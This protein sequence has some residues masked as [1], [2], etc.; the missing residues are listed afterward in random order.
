MVLEDKSKELVMKKLI[1]IIKSLKLKQ[2]LTVFLAGSL[3]AISTACSNDGNVAQ[4]GGKTYTDNAKRAMSD[5]YDD[6]DANQNFKGGINGYDDD[7][8]YDSETAGK[9]QTLIDTAKRRKADDLGEYTDNVLERSVL[10]GDVDEK[11]TESFSDKLERNK[12]KASNYIDNKS[13]KLQRNLERVPGETKEV[14]DK[15]ADTA[16]DA[17]QDASRAAE[18]NTNRVKNNF[19]DLT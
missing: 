11:A 17:A 1:K 6:Y 14:L 2:I 9:A 5:T 12:D 3:I 7:R 13:D 16:Q 8:R 19:E 15:A 18:K 4:A 10:N